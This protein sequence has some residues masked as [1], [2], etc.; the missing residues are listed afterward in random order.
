MQQPAEIE[1]EALPAGEVERQAEQVFASKVKLSTKVLVALLLLVVAVV[2]LFLGHYGMNPGETVSAALS[3]IPKGISYLAYCIQDPSLFSDPSF[4]IPVSNAERVLF[5]IRLPRVI[6][7][8]LV[9]AA[10]AVAGASYQGMFKNPLTSPDL[11]GASAGASLGACIALLLSLS[12]E[13]VQLFAFIGGMLAVGAAV[14]LNRLVD[15][16]PTLGL[17]LAGILVSTLFQSGMSLVKIMAD[18]NDKL[19]EITFWLMG[20]FASVNVADILVFIPMVVGFIILISQ[21]W[22]LN[23]LSFGDE[24]AR[25]MGV[26]TSRTR[27]LVIFASTMITSSSVAVAGIIGWIGL[28]IPHLARAVVGPNYKVL[29]PASMFIGAAYLLIVDDLARLLVSIEIPI[30]ILTA[31]LGVPFFVYIFKRNMKGWR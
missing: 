6:V 7:V 14:W 29:L 15:Y 28:V 4:S 10:L 25:A 19:P 13:F 22:K 30:G 8:V 20:S 2:S 27:L 18:S 23:V 11:L 26:N 16:D 3:F 12:G 5:Y 1:N 17:V 31:I 21:S 24:E 9:G